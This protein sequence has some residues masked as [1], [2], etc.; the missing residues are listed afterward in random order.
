[1]ITIAETGVVVKL[2][3]IVNETEIEFTV[4]PC[5]T[6]APSG[7]GKAASS[8]IQF[9]GA[10]KAWALLKE[11]LINPASAPVGKFSPALRCKSLKY[12]KYSCTFAP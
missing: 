11:T 3:F 8:Y 10:P 6:N 2:Y 5:F 12:T 7:A 4:L 1:M 9:E